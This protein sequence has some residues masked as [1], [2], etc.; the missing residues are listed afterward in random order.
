MGT[1]LGFLVVV[2]PIVLVGIAMWRSLAP[3]SRAKEDAKA[4][5]TLHLEVSDLLYRYSGQ[6]DIVGQALSDEIRTHLNNYR[7]EIDK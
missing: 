1:L 5:K 2:T 4:G 6:L 7:K 3:E